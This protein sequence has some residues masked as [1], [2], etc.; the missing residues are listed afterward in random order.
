MFI[1]Y[2]C[3]MS[4]LCLNIKCLNKELDLCINLRK[5]TIGF[6]LIFYQYNFK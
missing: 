3:N 1:L 6:L 2:M 4:I 5:F